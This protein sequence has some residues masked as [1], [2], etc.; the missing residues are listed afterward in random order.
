VCIVREGWASGFRLPRGTVLDVLS[1]T[2]QEESWSNL[3][4]KRPAGTTTHGLAFSDS[5][6]LPLELLVILLLHSVGI[7]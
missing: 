1:F 2:I 7:D 4:L 3:E 6:V 5:L